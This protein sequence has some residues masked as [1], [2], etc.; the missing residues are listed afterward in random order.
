MKLAI[1]GSKTDKTETISTRRANNKLISQWIHNF[2]FTKW[3][4]ANVFE[5]KID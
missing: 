5:N 1:M 3:L 2:D 4:S